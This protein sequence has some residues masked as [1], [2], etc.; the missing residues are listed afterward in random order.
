MMRGIRGATTV[1]ENDAESI[2]EETRK[3]LEEMVT[4]NKVL[5]SDVAHIWFTVTEEI[6]AAFPAKATRMLEGE[7]WTYVPVMCATEIPVPSGLKRCIRIMM[8]VNTDVPASE[9][10]HV[11]HNEAI[12]LRPDLAQKD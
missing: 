9:I 8:T 11:F 6:N 12:Q 4:E 5:P 1:K 3:C 7:E 10:V 2:W